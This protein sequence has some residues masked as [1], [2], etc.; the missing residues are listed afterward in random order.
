MPE[1]A[2]PRILLLEADDA[3]AAGMA[4]LLK[5]KGWEVMCQKVSKE[6][7]ALLDK[8]KADPF[9][10]FI[11]SYQLPKMS[12]DDV[13][14][15]AKA[16]S[17]LTQRML[18]VPS[19][20]S[21]LVIRAINKAE[22]NACLVTPVTDQ[23][24]I[25][26]IDAC[27][28]AFRKN[29]KIQRLK[30]VT[31]HQNKQMFQIAQKLRKK[32]KIFQDKI[33]EKKAEILLLRSRLKT[34]DPGKEADT[35][36]QRVL[37]LGIAL[38]PWALK[39]EFL[40]LADYSLALFDSAAAKAG[41]D[42][43]G[44]PNLTLPEED[45][46]APGI[47]PEFTALTDQI[48]KAAL[49]SPADPPDA[50]D[51]LD[52]TEEEGLAGMVD[53]T[54]SEDKT[55]AFAR[56]RTPP[57]GQMVMLNDFLDLLR[58]KEINFGILDDGALETWLRAPGFDP[59]CVARGEAPVP[60]KNGSVT[61]NFETAYSNPGKIMEDGRIDFR[62]RGD[63]PFVNKGDILAAKLM[64]KAGKDGVSV[65]GEAIVVDEPFDPVFIAGPGTSLSEDGTSIIAAL[66]GQP[67]L[68]H[69]GEISVNPELPI[70]GDVDFQ[71]GNINFKGH[72]IVSGTVKEGFTV[73]GF[74]L[75]AKEIEGATIDL[76]G[77]LQ[78]SDGI[79]DATIVSSGNIFAK[80]INNSKVKAFGNIAI[81]KEIIDSEVIISGKCDNTSGV[82]IASKVSAKGGIDA[83]RI[84]TGASKPAAL[85]VGVNEHLD[86]MT[87]E[88]ESRLK[89]SVD[90]LAGVRDKIR[91]VEDK[92]QDLYSQ[93][94]E[95]AQ[96][97][98][99][100]QNR[101]KTLTREMA[102]LKKN[103]DSQGISDLAARFKVEEATAKSAEKD[104]NSIFEIQN[105]FAKQISDYKEMADRI[106]ET[107]KNMMLRKKGLKEFGEKAEAVP[108]V[109]VAKGIAQD[110]V[111][112]GPNVS[113]TMKEDRRQC[114][115][116]EKGVSEEG[117]RFFEME[118]SDL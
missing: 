88:L 94:T 39:K 107:N 98:E 51:P 28:A 60:G 79:T 55:Q 62:D 103:G 69:L 90:K 118:I 54:L 81:Q 13:L 114:R 32:D 15:A 19:N 66:D 95:K 27:L 56:F 96:E 38:E 78:I 40:S 49:A 77:D 83:G 102:D 105:R 4:G 17:P 29:R 67:H 34:A 22:I 89:S 70:K 14:K 3:L 64:P 101:M 48:I 71:T 11:S 100:A 99:A 53:I 1:S 45:T 18:L 61:Y 75:T 35:L 72:I 36:A 6:A 52:D 116:E 104:L 43:E 115:I 84:G 46:A 25:S 58:L 65:A 42:R 76:T 21:D 59:F 50:P 2:S 112:S 10:L 41:L 92:D 57:E 110:T 23:D 106:E 24:L 91:E 108:R 44:P 12:G 85:K 37:N 26:Q 109:T 47:P 63:I 7:L 33:S 5:G 87:D 9:D 20:Q 68:D 16:I 117:L 111:I 86:L 73:K 30:R 80:F 8:A 93:I 31:V 97:Q 74:S 82:I 113:H